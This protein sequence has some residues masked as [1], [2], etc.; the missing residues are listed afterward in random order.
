MKKLIITLILRLVLFSEPVSAK[1]TKY[2]VGHTY[3][4]EITWKYKFNIKLP[5][6]KFKLL[7]RFDWTS[8]GIWE[9]GVWFVEQIE[10]NTFHQEISIY[11][12]GSVKYS[13]YLRQWY[14]T[15]FF[16]DQYDGR[17]KRPEYTLVEVKKKGFFNCWIIF[18][19]DI[20]K[21]LYSPDDP[22]STSGLWKHLIEKNNIEYPRIL[23]C[24][25]H[26]FFAA[27]IAEQVTVMNH[28]IN[29]ETFGGPKSKFVTEDS[30]EYHPGNIVKYPDHKKF[31][32][33]FIKES[34]YRHKLFEKSLTARGKHKIDLSHYGVTGV[35]EETK[36]TTT[37]TSSGSSSGIN[38]QLEKLY[39]L[40]K[41]GALTEEEF[42][43]AKDKVLS[44]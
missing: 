16:K 43:K 22:Q 27:S 9:K 17:Y 32:E 39:D 38:Q 21:E 6:G 44:Q 1:K 25:Y 29:P 23:V 31:M 24:S 20:Q 12:V 7:D 2:V 26:L 19:E 15:Y 33:K 3:E 37:T 35:I 41:E 40:Y 5:P 30:S 11:N 34:A 18:H 13:A 10:E 36:T 28:C 8:W 14:H 4:D 42:Q